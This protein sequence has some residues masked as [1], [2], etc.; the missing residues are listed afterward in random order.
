MLSLLS[1]PSSS[2]YEQLLVQLSI[3]IVLASNNKDVPTSSSWWVLVVEPLHPNQRYRKPSQML[4]ASL[5][6]NYISKTLINRCTRGLLILLTQVHTLLLLSEHVF[7]DLITDR[8]YLIGLQ[9]VHNYQLILKE[10]HLIFLAVV[11]A[12]LPEVV[13][14]CA[15][16]GTRGR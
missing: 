1:P 16:P 15:P 13:E 7:L 10:L 12:H 11:A 9:R 14:R 5:C 6:N 2:R 4:L 8:L 3:C